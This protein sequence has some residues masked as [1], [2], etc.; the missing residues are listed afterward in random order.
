MV[1][2]KPTM[3]ILPAASIT[4]NSE[5]AGLQERCFKGP[6]SRAGVNGGV[7]VGS[8]RAHFPSPGW[9]RRFLSSKAAPLELMVA[10]LPHLDHA[11]ALVN[12]SEICSP[13]VHQA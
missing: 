9:Q 11:I 2:N 8:L 5:P 3:V 13:Y 6:P 10:T 4:A 7:V 1:A 12:W